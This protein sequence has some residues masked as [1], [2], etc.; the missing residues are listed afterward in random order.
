LLAE[1]GKV[2]IAD[3]RQ[4]AIEKALA[5]VVNTASMAG[6]LASGAPGITTRPSSPCA[7]NVLNRCATTWPRMAWRVDPCPGLVKSYFYASDDVRPKELSTAPSPSTQ[8]TCS[9]GRVHEFGMEPDV[10][11]ARVL[12]GMRENRPISRIEFKDEVMSCFRISCRFP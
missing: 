4:D 5:L 6:W 1:G 9:V 11:A 8:P 7:Q 10:I 3:I 12:D 2:A